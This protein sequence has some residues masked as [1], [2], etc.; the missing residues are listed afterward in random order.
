MEAILMHQPGG[1]EVLRSHTIPTPTLQRD[2]ELLVRLRAAGVNPVHTKIRQRGPYHANA[3]PMI[4]GCDGAGMVEAIGPGVRH[5]SVGDEVYFCHGGLGAA[6]GNYAEYTVIDERWVAPKPTCLSFEQAAA[7]PLVL[8]AAWEALYDR[9]RLGMGQRVLIHGGAGGVGHVAIQLAK[10]REAHVCTTISTEDKAN[11]VTALGVDHAIYYPRI[12]FVAGVMNWTGD[13][14]VDVAFDTVG[15]PVLSRTFAA[16][17]PYG[18]IVTLLSPTPDTD[19]KTART[20]NL[21]VGYELMLTPALQ[22]LTQAQQHQVRI[23][24]ECTRWFDAGKLHIHVGQTFP[25]SQAAEA[26][27]LVESGQVIGKVVLQMPAG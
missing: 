17:K 7:A 10:L 25:L 1:P 14:G 11:F 26:H 8:I 6:P 18:D 4:L 24:Q 22:G 27:R 19:W 15:E 23:L 16:V 12:D 20:R 2:T 3:L 9:A 21:R 13:Q 5:Y